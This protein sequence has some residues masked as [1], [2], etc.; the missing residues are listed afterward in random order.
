MS[1]RCAP[2]TLISALLGIAASAATFS[3][4]EAAS[5]LKMGASSGAGMVHLAGLEQKYD[6]YTRFYTDA[7]PDV[8]IYTCNRKSGSSGVYVVS[9]L[10][11]RDLHVCWTLVFNDGSESKGCK[12]RLRAGEESASSCYS[13]NTGNK[14]V[15]DVIWHRI[16]PAS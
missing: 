11:G 15:R 5:T 12:S 7:Y 4:S 2:P 3:S 16:D 14:G 10:T 1:I 13:C 9:N 8:S 6:C